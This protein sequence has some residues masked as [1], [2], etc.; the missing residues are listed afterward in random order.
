M[1]D[2]SAILVR[3]VPGALCSVSLAS[4]DWLNPEYDLYEVLARDTRMGRARVYRAYRYLVATGCL[5]E[6]V[7]GRRVIAACRAKDEELLK[8]LERELLPV[9]RVPASNY[10]NL[11]RLNEAVSRLLSPTWFGRYPMSAV[12]ALMDGNWA[13]RPEA[14]QILKALLEM[15]AIRVSDALRPAGYEV[16]MTRQLSPKDARAVLA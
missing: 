15:R 12:N 11:D 13:S 14:F 1:I 5:S 10:V 2:T 9:T 4:Y 3:I 16:M 7:V 8:L 6:L